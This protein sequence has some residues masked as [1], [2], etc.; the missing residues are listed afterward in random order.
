[1]RQPSLQKPSPSALRDFI[2]SQRGLAFTYDGVGATAGEPP[3]GYVVDRVRAPLGHGAEAFAAARRRLEQWQQFNLGWV[4]A[5]PRDTPIRPGEQVAVVARAM[6][7]WWTNVARIVYVVD[8]TGDEQGGVA[9]FGFAYGTL[10][11]HVERGE[12]RF[13]I[14]WNRATD[15][16]DFNILAFSRP[17]HVLARLGYPQ[18]RRMQRRFGRDAAR[19]MQRV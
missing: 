4:E 15:E 3:G 12:E 18:V 9:R 8:E 13:L 6:G 2:E 11:A 16:V 10:P 7:L 19:A 14:E 5:W 17:R 1:M